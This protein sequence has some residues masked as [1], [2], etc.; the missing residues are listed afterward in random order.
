MENLMKSLRFRMRPA[1]RSAIASVLSAAA[2]FGANGVSAAEYTLTDS[3]NAD[4]ISA[5]PTFLTAESAVISNTGTNKYTEYSILPPGSSTAARYNLS[6]SGTGSLEI[7]N[8]TSSAPAT[9][10]YLGNVST[11]GVNLTLSLTS[12]GN[13]DSL[14]VDGGAVLY[15]K[16]NNFWNS[17]DFIY[18]AGGGTMN[19]QAGGN[20]HLTGAR[21]I[22]TTAPASPSAPT[23]SAWASYLNMNGQNLTF[24]L[25]E[26]TTLT[27]SGGMGNYGY[28][29]KT[30]AGTLI[31]SAANGFGVYQD[32]TLIAG[33]NNVA[34]RANTISE[35]TLRVTG[36]G[37]LSTTQRSIT[38]ADGVTVLENQWTNVVPIINNGTIEL[39]SAVA[40]DIRNLS[41]TN[42]ASLIT[43]T[44]NTASLTL[45][46]DIDT[47]YAGAIRGNSLAL[48]KSGTGNLAVTGSDVGTEWNFRQI[49]VTGGGKL[50][51][52]PV[53]TRNVTGNFKLTRLGTVSLDGSELELGSGLF[54]VSISGEIQFGANGG[55][56]TTPVNFHANGSSLR[57][58]TT[59]NGAASVLNCSLNVNVHTPEFFAA[60]NS[61]LTVTGDLWNIGG[62]QKTGTGTLILSADSRYGNCIVKRN[63]TDSVYSEFFTDLQNGTVQIGTN[64]PFGKV[65]NSNAMA[66]GTV[67]LNTRDAADTVTLRTKAGTNLTLNNYFDAD[68]IGANVLAVDGD[69][70]TIAKIGGTG[71][72]TKTGAG[73]LCLG[74]IT[75]AE[76]DA[77][78]ANYTTNPDSFYNGK[79]YISPLN[80]SLQGLNVTEGA[81]SVTG[82]AGLTVGNAVF[83]GA[84]TLYI[85]DSADDLLIVTDSLSF[86]DGAKIRN[87]LEAKP[88]AAPVELFRLAE[89]S[90]FDAAMLASLLVNP[91]EN[92]LFQQT[93]TSL[94]AVV[95]SAALPEPGTWFLGVLGIFGLGFL[96]FRTRKSS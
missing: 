31:F 56:L 58:S 55:K 89:G 45:Y 21:T 51:L 6:V 70:L 33:K 82:T 28:Y 47:T 91:S 95:N 53:A 11:N 27:Q 43:N 60:E 59:V 32:H 30:G 96:R 94:Y 63:S 35:G 19:M 74:G 66:A 69:S 24:N 49:T 36:N 65:N 79:T 78:T 85:I 18:G 26:N 84:S 42:A 93:G 68:G 83:S 3:A 20:F 61:T 29:T 57:I 90:T 1:F 17:G 71:T 15:I 2:V 34:S 38:Q 52:A 80:A 14:S 86:T 44:N 12:G 54:Q 72:L 41:G 64:N 75:Q 9:G 76:I 92:W 73:T 81:F 4:F 48:T 25:A 22:R 39:A 7:S 50:S 8:F 40:Q 10:F 77:A 46:N 37:L 5:L 62:I 88:G 16:G 67:K 23:V 87:D 13:A